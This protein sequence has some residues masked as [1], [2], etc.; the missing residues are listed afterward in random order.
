M[1]KL[2]WEVL[3]EEQRERV[4]WLEKELRGEGEEE[5]LDGEKMAELTK[6]L[7]GLIAAECPC[8]G[9]LMIESVGVPLEGWDDEGLGGQ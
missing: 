8:T 6:E 3:N 1:R 5:M 9:D 2:V 4:E 7:D